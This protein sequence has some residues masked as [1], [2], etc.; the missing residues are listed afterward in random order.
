M[1][2]FLRRP[3]VWVVWLCI[4][5]VLL[6][7]PLS[8]AQDGIHWAAPSLSF[9]MNASP[10][11][12]IGNSTP[13]TPLS[14]RNADGTREGTL[15]WDASLLVYQGSMP[16]EEAT[17]AFWEVWP[18]GRRHMQILAL[19]GPDRAYL[20]LDWSRGPGRLRCETESP[21]AP[22]AEELLRALGCIWVGG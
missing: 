8:Q 20:L 17:A 6:C 22:S 4:P 10:L 18:W 12:F 3:W 11:L 16:I 9:N 15:T 19:Y 14:W 21:R 5:S 2:R 7:L 1:S 13:V